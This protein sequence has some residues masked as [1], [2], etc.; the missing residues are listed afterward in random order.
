M[1][2]DVPPKN[3]A[4]HRTRVVCFDPTAA[5]A[6]RTAADIPHYRTPTC[7]WLEDRTRVSCLYLLVLLVLVLVLLL[8][9]H[10]TRPYVLFTE[11][12]NEGPPPASISG[13]SV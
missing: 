6:V 8:A 1:E 12:Q 2:G 11:R 3:K 13:C 7:C 10:T 4:A 5:T 9:Y